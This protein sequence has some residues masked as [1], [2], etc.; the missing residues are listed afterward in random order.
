MRKA[1]AV[2]DDFLNRLTMYKLLFFGL[3]VLL[4]GGIVFSA[5]G[6]LFFSAKALI[7][8]IAV[9]LI[10]CYLA[11]KLMAIIMDA[12]TNIESWLITAL[13]LACILQPETSVYKLALIALGGLLAMLSKYLVA[14]RHYHIFNPAAFAAVVL[15]VTKLLPAIWWIG[16]PQMLILTVIFGL[17]ILR[18]LHRYQLFLVFLIL[19][20]A[21]TVIIGLGHHLSASDVIETAF[22]SSP[23]IFLGTVMLTEPITLPASRKTQLIYAA[24]VGLIF[25]SQLSV[26]SVSATPEVALVIGNIFAFIVSPKYKLKL[27]LESKRQLT[28]LLYDFGFASDTKINF[29]PGQYM[30]WT[31][32]HEHA[33]IRGNRRSFSIASAPEDKELHMV[34][35]LQPDK[36]SSFKSKLNKLNKGDHITVGKLA[37]HFIMPKD[38]SEKLIFIAGGVGITPFHSMISSLVKRNEQ[39]DIVVFYLVSDESEYCFKD[40]WQQAAILGVKVIPVLTH[41]ET[42]SNWPGLKGRLSEAMIKDSISDYK[43]RKYYL[44]GPNGFVVSYKRLLRGLGIMQQSI[45]S[46]YFSGY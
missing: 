25:T 14:Y 16:D 42:S 21:L 27:K 6:A 5:T 18:K 19:S 30:E 8:T 23:L 41:G 26:G 37:G 1:L 7:G 35:R 46:D 12:D 2:I 11:N 24:I 13:I 15:G 3:I 20:I 40:I 45:V 32:P 29:T 17:L 31:L 10:V 28:P 4:I 22:K 39:R 33:D 38:K 43:D 36:S 34:V 9:L 44:S